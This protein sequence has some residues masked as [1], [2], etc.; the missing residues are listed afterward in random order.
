MS[1]TSYIG[2]TKITTRGDTADPPARDGRPTREGKSGGSAQPR[3]KAVE[4]VVALCTAREKCR[5]ALLLYTNDRIDYA[6]MAPV[7][8]DL[9]AAAE[10]FATII[11]SLEQLATAAEDDGPSEELPT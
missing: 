2:S 10:R 3:T 5:K 9:V 11:D 1:K 4:V 6:T 7:L 8:A